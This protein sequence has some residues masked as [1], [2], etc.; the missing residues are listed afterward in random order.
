MKRVLKPAFLATLPVMTG[1]L[2]LGFGFGLVLM[3][4][5]AAFPWRW[6]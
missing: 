1:Y 5:G 3:D 4:A 2:V 6:P